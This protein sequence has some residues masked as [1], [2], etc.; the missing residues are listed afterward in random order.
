MNRR[1]PS[2]TLLQASQNHPHLARLMD[3]QRASQERL[4]AI[5]SLIPATLHTH[6][7]AG[8][9]DEGVWCLLLANN[10]TAAKLRQLLPALEAHLRTQGLDVKSI[11]LK[12]QRPA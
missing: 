11:R 1:A 5:L 3:I 7:R 2:F 10:T 12:V 4:Q 6:V 8:P 9:L